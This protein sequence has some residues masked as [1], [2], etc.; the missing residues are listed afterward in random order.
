MCFGSRAPDVVVQAPKPEQKAPEPLPEPPK[1]EPIKETYKPLTPQQ[2]LGGVQQAGSAQR[3][4]GMM[5]GR[6]L[7]RRRQRLS[8]G[9]ASAGGTFPSGGI[10]L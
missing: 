10:N 6:G 9:I 3:R 7:G 2:Y 1:P 8:T 4:A 5:A